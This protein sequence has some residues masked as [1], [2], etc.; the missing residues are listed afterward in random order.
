[1]RPL[2]ALLG[3]RNPGGHTSQAEAPQQAARKFSLLEFPICHK[4]R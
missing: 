2:A 4:N 3:N 1:M